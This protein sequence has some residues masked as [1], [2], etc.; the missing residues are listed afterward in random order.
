M[1]ELKLIDICQEIGSISQRNNAYTCFLNASIDKP[2]EKMTVG[3]LL[4][5]HNE[6]LKQFNTLSTVSGGI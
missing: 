4:Q 6:C 3:E 1:N 2:I 5:K